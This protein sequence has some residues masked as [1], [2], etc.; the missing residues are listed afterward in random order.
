MRDRGFMLIELA[1]ASFVI[2]V[3]LLALA[4]ILH[5]GQR[6]ATDSDAA[7]RAALFADDA[8]STLRL[9]NDRAASDPDAEAWVKMW[10]NL[11]SGSVITQL[12]GFASGVWV[13]DW[14]DSLPCLDTSLGV[15]T[16]FWCPASVKQEGNGANFAR[17][18]V[19]LRYA[20]SIVPS[21]ETE[22]VGI[23]YEQPRYYAVTLN[24][25]S[26]TSLTTESSDTTFFAVF[27]NQ[28]RMP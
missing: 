2:G 4:A 12:T 27:T 25:W 18:D 3:A 8:I 20:V 23:G 28:R 6:A 17:A 15:H 26:G 10:S 21:S 14:N 22:D 5:L 9:M 7:T 24:V 16:N 19:A 1:V 13:S 11:L